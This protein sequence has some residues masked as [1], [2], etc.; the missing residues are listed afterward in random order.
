MEGNYPGIIGRQLFRRQLS[1]VILLEA[2]TWGAI[3]PG[4]IVLG[5]IILVG[6]GSICP[7]EQ[8]SMGQLSGGN[9][10]GDNFPRTKST[11]NSLACLFAVIMNLFFH[12]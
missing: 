6:G 5:K 10:P 12:S 1:G 2:T 4:A 3:I 8:L 7:G 11:D 9:Y